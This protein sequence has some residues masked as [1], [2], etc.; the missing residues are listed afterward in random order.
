[1]TRML[2]IAQNSQFSDKIDCEAT[3]VRADAYLQKNHPGKGIPLKT[4]QA[5]LAI[6]WELYSIVLKPIWRVKF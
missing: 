5:S 4:T 1:M 3:K 2:D 6:F